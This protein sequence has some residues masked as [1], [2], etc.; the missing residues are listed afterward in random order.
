MWE[1]GR[2]LVEEVFFEDEIELFENQIIE[3]EI[4]E[5]LEQ[6]VSIGRFPCNVQNGATT[7]QRSVSGQTIPQQLRISLSKGVNIVYDKTYQVRI[8]K[9]RIRFTSELWNVESITEG[10]L[11]TVISASRKVSV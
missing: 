3:N 2:A 5:E 1:E 4:G 6:P 9:A 11:S 8:I 7:V 10:Q